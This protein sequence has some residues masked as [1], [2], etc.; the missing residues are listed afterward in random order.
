MLEELKGKTQEMMEELKR[1]PKMGGEATHGLAAAGSH[2]P[3]QG[4]G[5][6]GRSGIIGV[7]GWG[8]PAGVV[9]ITTARET[10]GEYTKYTTPGRKWDRKTSASIFLLSSDDSYWPNLTL[11]HLAGE[12]EDIV[13]RGQPM[14][15]K[16]EQKKMRKGDESKQTINQPR[17][18][19]N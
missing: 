11:W 2:D 14:Q 15:S 9:R 12:S 19:W 8:G 17:W 4:W 16:T 10:Q 1:K 7:Q 3:F 18:S 5:N 6:K 13:Y